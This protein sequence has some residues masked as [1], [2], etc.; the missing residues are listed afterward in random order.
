MRCVLA[1]SYSLKS[2]TLIFTK[3]ILHRNENIVSYL[4]H[5]HAHTHTDTIHH[6]H[7]CLC[8]TVT[9]AYFKTHS[10]A[11][12]RFYFSV[13]LCLCV[14]IIVFGSINVTDIEMYLLLLRS[15][16]FSNIETMRDLCLNN[17]FYYKH[18]PRMMFVRMHNTSTYYVCGSVCL[19]CLLN[20]CLFV[21]DNVKCECVNFAP[22]NIL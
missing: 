22:E 15:L 3:C 12:F 4:N 1:H 13:Y 9:L 20:E 14:W 21:W 16:T 6:K 18:D 5:T 10:L 11:L 8:I 2:L 17:F 19:L 7:A